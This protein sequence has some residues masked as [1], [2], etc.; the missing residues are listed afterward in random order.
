[1][2]PISQM[3][4]LGLTEV[5]QVSDVTQFASGKA[6][7]LSGL[8]D[9]ESLLCP[10]NM[11]SLDLH[12]LAG[13]GVCARVWTPAPAVGFPGGHPPSGASN[14]VQHLTLSSDC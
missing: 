14:K 3:K 2:G 10:H 4:K 11:L 13:T 1:M 6:G 8:S 7:I 12:H 9:L 5:K